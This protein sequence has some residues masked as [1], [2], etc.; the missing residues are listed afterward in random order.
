MSTVGP[1]YGDEWTQ[2]FVN[3]PNTKPF[4][5]DFKGSINTMYFSMAVPPVA[6]TT[7]DKIF[8]TK[9]PKGARVL[10]IK[11]SVPDQGSVGTYNL[12]WD[13]SADVDPT[14][15][16]VLEAAN[17]TGFLSAIDCHTGATTTVAGGAGSTVVPAGI[18]KKFLA[19]VNLIMQVQAVWDVGVGPIQGVMEYVN[20]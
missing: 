17:L 14:T 4:P 15:K 2:M 9:I 12:G 16:V 6:P 11:L 8:L 3:V 19:E 7:L 13:D 18:L 20:Y 1:Y 5:G 10:S